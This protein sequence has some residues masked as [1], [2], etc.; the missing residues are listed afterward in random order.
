M[1]EEVIG[2]F[3]L[4][5]KKV[6]VLVL[7]ALLLP[8]AALAEDTEAAADEP[9]YVVD[10][11][12]DTALD[13]TQYQGKVVFLNF[14]EEWCVYCM[15]EMPDIKK[16]FELYDPDGLEI[17]LVHPWN[18]EDASN[19]ESVVAKYGLEGITTIEDE[20]MLLQYIAGLNGYPTSL[21]IDADG[22][23]AEY[24]PGMLTYETMLEILDGLG[25]PRLDTAAADAEATAEPAN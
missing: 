9:L 16:A 21:F 13:L 18:G 19:T 8:A 12:N 14:F 20:D 7:A 22:Y 15:E 23:L 24:V 1:H 5:I 25:V 17:I 4:T 11:F 2:L 6:L 3:K 10:Y